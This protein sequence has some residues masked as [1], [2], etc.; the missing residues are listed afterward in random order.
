MR[1]ISQSLSK[2]WK[3]QKTLKRNYI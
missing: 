1:K 3:T 2:F